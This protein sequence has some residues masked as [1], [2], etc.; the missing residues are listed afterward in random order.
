[1]ASNFNEMTPDTA[2]ACGITAFFLGGLAFTR[3]GI[4]DGLCSFFLAVIIFM[5]A[6]YSEK[7]H[8]V[9]AFIATLVWIVAYFGVRRLFS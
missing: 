8:G 9:S 2:I 4:Q 1:M 6:K 3:S 5:L 7:S